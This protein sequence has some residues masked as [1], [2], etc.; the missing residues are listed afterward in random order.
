MVITILAVSAAF[1]GLVMAISPILQ[2]RRMI[3]RRS[4][5]DVSLGYYGLL[6]PGFALWIAYGWARGDYA[7]VVPNSVALAV[8]IATIVIA[9][10][11]RS[12]HARRSLPYN[13][14]QSLR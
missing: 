3:R 7:L 10:I 4:S 6:L 1:W 13:V 5:D 14:R 2:I 8:G 11:L 9:R 12:R